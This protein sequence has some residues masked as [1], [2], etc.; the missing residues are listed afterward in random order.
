MRRTLAEIL[1]PLQSCEALVLACTHYPAIAPLIREILPD[2]HLL[3][4]AEAT[5]RYIARRWQIP[6]EKV[7]ETLFVTTGNAKEMKVAAQLAFGNKIEKVIEVG[8]TDRSWPARL[9]NRRVKSR[10]RELDRQPSSQDPKDR[11]RESVER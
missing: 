9:A 3:D 8:A 10:H 1:K 5:A 2:C 4:P 7:G 6:N 11:H